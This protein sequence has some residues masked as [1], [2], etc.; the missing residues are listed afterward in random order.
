M[1]RYYEVHSTTDNGGKEHLIIDVTKISFLIHNEN[2]G[3][4]G[5]TSICFG[6]S[7]YNFTGANNK[8]LY[9]EIRKIMLQLE[10]GE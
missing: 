5:R 2:E 9:D 1:K 4:H 3:L 8:I 10:K 7:Q 6:L